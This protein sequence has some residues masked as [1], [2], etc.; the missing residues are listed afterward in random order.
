MWPEP[1]REILDNLRQCSK[2]PD[3]LFHIIFFYLLKS[4]YVNFKHVSLQIKV[5]QA[6]HDTPPLC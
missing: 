4:T 3:H 1:S 2:P 5:V 6:V